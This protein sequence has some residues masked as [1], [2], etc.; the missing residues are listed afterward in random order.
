[1]NKIAIMEKILTNAEICR[2]KCI[3]CGYDG[4]VRPSTIFEW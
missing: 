1:M 4:G 2:R 3:N